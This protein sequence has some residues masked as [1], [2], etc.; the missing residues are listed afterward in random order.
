MDKESIKRMWRN[1]A[2]N[3]L[4]H[5]LNEGETYRLLIKNKDGEIVSIN[6]SRHWVGPEEDELVERLAAYEN[7]GLSPE[8]VEILTKAVVNQLIKLVEESND[9]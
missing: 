3:L 4:R 7:T 8:E 2:L 9:E 1:R 6:K 5:S